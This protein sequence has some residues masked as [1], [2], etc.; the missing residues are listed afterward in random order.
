[1]GEDV[2]Q[3]YLLYKIFT[4]TDRQRKG[5]REGGRERDRE[6][7]RERERERK[8]KGGGGGWGRER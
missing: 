4:H 7:E 5:G 8:T 2:T 1:M 6:R 3:F